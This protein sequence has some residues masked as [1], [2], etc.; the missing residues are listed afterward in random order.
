MISEYS[1]ESI[2]LLDLP[3]LLKEDEMV[4]LHQSGHILDGSLCQKIIIEALATSSQIRH[5]ASYKIREAI[6]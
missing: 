6:E 2:T 4:I 1:N 3:K 5:D